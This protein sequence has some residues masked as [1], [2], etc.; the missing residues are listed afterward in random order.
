MTEV[1][2]ETK[3]VFIR[4]DLN[5]PLDDAGRITDDTRIRASLDA[6]RFALSK[7]A[8]LMATSHL[9]RPKEGEFSEADSLARWPLAWRS[10]LAAKCRS[11]ATGS[12]RW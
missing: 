6:Y 7:G 8:A 1:P 3:R 9:G 2:L 5:V 4:S 10:S 11:C 12:T